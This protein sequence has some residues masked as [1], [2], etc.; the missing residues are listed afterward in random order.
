MV[1]RTSHIAILRLVIAVC[2]GQLTPA[3]LLPARAIILKRQ[4]PRKIQHFLNAML[5]QRL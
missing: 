4:K 3:E 5:R 1:G 2:A